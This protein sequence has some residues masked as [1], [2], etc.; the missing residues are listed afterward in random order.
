MG[1]RLWA[2]APSPGRRG[3]R[4]R[5]GAP[6]S[7]GA[8]GRTTTRGCQEAGRP[9]P[10]TAAQLPTLT[11]SWSPAGLGRP[12][13]RTHGICGGTGRTRR[14]GQRLRNQAIL[15]V[16]KGRPDPPSKAAGVSLPAAQLPGREWAA[17]G[18]S[19]Q[20]SASLRA[21][22]PHQHPGPR[23]SIPGPRP[24]TPRPRPAPLDPGSAPPGTLAGGPEHHPDGATSLSA[25]GNC[26]WGTVIGKHPACPGA[27]LSTG[28][29]SRSAKVSLGPQTQC[30]PSRKP[31]RACPR[32]P[33]HRRAPSCQRA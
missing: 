9:P 23:P 22:L 11:G 18:P 15:G 16:A 33:P 14:T 32:R 3:P 30:R 8:Q 5:A 31:A 20:W 6:G 26:Q 29:P 1:A 4:G 13:G 7:G 19:T 24:S 2:P 25:H 27:Q 28:Q 21:P 17:G 10:S 12:R